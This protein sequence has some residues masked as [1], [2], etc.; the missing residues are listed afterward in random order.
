MALA[1]ATKVND[2]QITLSPSPAPKARCAKCKAAVQ[3]ATAKAY[4]TPMYSAK[5]L[6]N[7]AVTGPIESQRECSTSVTASTSSA[8]RSMSARGTFQ[9]AKVEPPLYCFKFFNGLLIVIM[10]SYI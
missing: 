8:P 2:G 1:V 5:Y 6:S 7:S 4:F 10:V 3:F 9:L